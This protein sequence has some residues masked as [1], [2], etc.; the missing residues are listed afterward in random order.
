M[1]REGPFSPYITRFRFANAG[2][3]NRAPV[4]VGGP[5]QLLC[6]VCPGDKLN[7]LGQK[8]DELHLLT[9]C[10]AVESVRRETGLS[11]FLNQGRLHGLS[12]TSLFSLYVNGLDLRGNPVSKF[13]YLFRGRVVKSLVEAFLDL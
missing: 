2:L 8:N 3:G 12:D 11:S 10:N 4:T 1:C 5:R 9:Q 6:P 7:Q 13:D